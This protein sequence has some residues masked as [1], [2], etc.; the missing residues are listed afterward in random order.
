MRGNT[1]QIP[2]TN[3]ETLARARFRSRIFFNV[4]V[5][6]QDNFVKPKLIDVKLYAD[7]RK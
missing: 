7:T 2:V 6:F 3:G 5:K 4:T 1:V